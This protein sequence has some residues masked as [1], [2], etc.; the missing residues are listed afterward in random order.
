[1]LKR[2]NFITTL[3][4][5]VLA[6]TLP[7]GA[8][9]VIQT[10]EGKG[11]SLGNRFRGLV[12]TDFRLFDSAGVARK[13]RLIAVD[14]GPKCPGLEQFSIVFEGDELGEGLYQIRSWRTGR[15]L[16]NLQTSGE[17]GTAGN[18]QRACFSNFA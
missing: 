4:A 6:A 18:R 9:A 2:R 10:H 15:I 14:D 1:M 13:A 3:S 7:T 17:P 8:T 11:S 12:D 5:T 16:I